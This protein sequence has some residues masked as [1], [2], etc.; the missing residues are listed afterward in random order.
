MAFIK[1][2]PSKSKF[3]FAA[4]VF[5]TLSANVMQICAGHEMYLLSGT[6]GSMKTWIYTAGL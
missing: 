5:L 2:L 4:L 3:V 6:G 1:L